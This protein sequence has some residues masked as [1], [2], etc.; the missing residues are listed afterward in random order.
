M[1][2]FKKIQSQDTSL[3]PDFGNS[4]GRINWE[5]KILE[6]RIKLAKI[7][8]PLAYVSPKAVISDGCV[9]M[10][11]AIVN[12]GTVIKIAYIINIGTIIDNDCILEEGCHLATGAIVKG[13]N[14]LP[15]GMKVDS[16]EVILLQYYKN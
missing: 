1:W 8:H 12:T 5:N 15:E 16:R 7:I 9:F 4:K 13:E 2:R 14:Y 10:L 3:Y 6:A 11:Y